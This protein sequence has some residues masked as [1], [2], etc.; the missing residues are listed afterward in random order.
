M[1]QNNICYKGNLYIIAV[2]PRYFEFDFD[3][4]QSADNYIIACI[5]V[6]KDMYVYFGGK[7]RV[8]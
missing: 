7:T 6:N 8:L 5:D 1:L 4:N 3:Y 2:V